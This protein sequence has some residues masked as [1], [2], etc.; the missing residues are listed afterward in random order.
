M[1]CRHRCGKSG[2]DVTLLSPEDLSHG[3]LSRFDA[4][5]TGVRAWNT[6]ADLRANYSAP[7]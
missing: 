7:V 6:R 1:K 2:C 4:I 3:D 5:V